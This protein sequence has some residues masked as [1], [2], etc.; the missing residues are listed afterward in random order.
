MTLNVNSRMY[1][2]D[3]VTFLRHRQPI[4]DRGRDASPPVFC[5][6]K[7]G[8]TQARVVVLKHRIKQTDEIK[9]NQMSL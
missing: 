1:S 2:N 3:T 5:S 4:T 6:W 9:S 8:R 7:D